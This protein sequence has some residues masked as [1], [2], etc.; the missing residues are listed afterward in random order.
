MTNDAIA[1]CDL[2]QDLAIST[3]MLPPQ[4]PPFFI[5]EMP[6]SFICAEE[7]WPVLKKAMQ[8]MKQEE[9]KQDACCAPLPPFLFHTPVSAEPL[10]SSVSA[11]FSYL[12]EKIEGAL[13][14]VS[15]T[16]VEQTSFLLSGSSSLA[17]T[18]IVIREYSTAP[19]AFNIEIIASSQIMA[20]LAP[21]MPGL[22]AALRAEHQPFLVNRVDALLSKQERPLFERKGPVEREDT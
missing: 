8:E 18:E 5:K 3:T 14:I 15:K 7:S 2:L 16:D 17:G 12:L 19:K 20:Q 10:I 11:D 13:I 6:L 22:L 4:P 21:H 1:P 9:L